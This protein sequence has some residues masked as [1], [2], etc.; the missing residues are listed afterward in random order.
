MHITYIYRYVTPIISVFVYLCIC[1]DYS[2]VPLLVQENYIDAAK[3]SGSMRTLDEATRMEKLSQ[4]A[5]AVSDF[6]IVGPGKMGQDMH[7]EL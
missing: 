5:D 4:A 6:D 7:W 2:L 3:G 1:V